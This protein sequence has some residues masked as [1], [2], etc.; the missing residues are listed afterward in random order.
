M[1]LRDQI[2]SAPSKGLTPVPVPE[3]GVTVYVR[4]LSVSETEKAQ[5]LVGASDYYA[6]LAAFI[7]FDEHG[8]RVFTEEDAKALSDKDYA[9]LDRVFGVYATVNGKPAKN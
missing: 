6:Q 4:A 3:W 1:S 7:I 9:P 8:N 5:K 2:L